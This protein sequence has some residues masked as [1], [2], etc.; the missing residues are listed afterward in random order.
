MRA[1]EAFGQALDEAF[2][3]IER[4]EAASVARYLQLQQTVNGGA[5][6]TVDQLRALGFYQGGKVTISVQMT[7]WHERQR[8]VSVDG[9]VSYGPVQLHAGFSQQTSDGSR[10]YI[11]IQAELMHV[12]RTDGMQEALDALQPLPPLPQDGSMTLSLSGT[13]AGPGNG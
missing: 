3:A 13:T 12:I 7:S 8:Q 9:G 10:D 1:G 2:E 5:K 11:S 4:R 6:L